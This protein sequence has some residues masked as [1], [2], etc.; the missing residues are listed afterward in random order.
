MT[1]LLFINKMTALS[2]SHAE[3]HAVNVIN[4]D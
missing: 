3:E 4:I 2:Y 1:I